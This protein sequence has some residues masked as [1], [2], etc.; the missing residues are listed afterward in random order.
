MKKGENFWKDLLTLNLCALHAMIMRIL[1]K[2]YKNYNL[3]WKKFRDFANFL[4]KY[5]KFKNITAKLLPPK[6]PASN[7]NSNSFL[8]LLN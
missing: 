3:I 4:N 7:T 1:K 5:W 8:E 6:Y 2:L